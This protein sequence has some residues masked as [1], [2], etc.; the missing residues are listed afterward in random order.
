MTTP[1]YRLVFATSPD[2]AAWT[3]GDPSASVVARYGDGLGGFVTIFR[4]HGAMHPGACP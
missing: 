3:R 4:I 2:Y 1:P